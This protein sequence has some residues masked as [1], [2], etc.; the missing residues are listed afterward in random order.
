MF[1]PVILSFF[2]PAEYH[3]HSSNEYEAAPTT[4]GRKRR[5][6]HPDDLKS[7]EKEMISFI[8]PNEKLELD[9][10]TQKEIE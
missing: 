9:E 3:S 1:L 2:G 8:Q 7:N 5:A 6:N 4:N 10:K